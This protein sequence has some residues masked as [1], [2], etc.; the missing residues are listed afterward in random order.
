MELKDLKASI[1]ELPTDE[2]MALLKDIRQSRRTPKKVH[3]DRHTKAAPKQSKAAGPDLSQLL[4]T[5]SPEQILQIL[6]KGK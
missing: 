5:M 4:K 2:L 1:T 6:G 3:A